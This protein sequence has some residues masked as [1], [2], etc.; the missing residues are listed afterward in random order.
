MGLLAVC[1]LSPSVSFGHDKPSKAVMT[2]LA[3]SDEEVLRGAVEE[4]QTSGDSRVPKLCLPLLHAGGDSIRRL[5]LRAIGSRY[6]QIPEAERA[7]YVAAIERLQKTEKSSV[8][9]RMAGRAL[10]L[11]RREYQADMFAPNPKGDLVAYER[12][13]L[14]CVLDTGRKT[15]TLIGKREDDLL[16]RFLPSVGNEAVRPFVWWNV[17]GSVA[18]FKMLFGRHHSGIWV[19][20]ENRNH[21]V[22]L[23]G[24]AFRKVT[25]VGRADFVV[26]FLDFK[27]W[28]GDVL[29]MDFYS[30]VAKP[31]G[32][33]RFEMSELSGNAFYDIKTGAKTFIPTVKN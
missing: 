21:H 20:F 19:W 9:L 6:A 24:E 17:N 14:P 5:A 10:G 22:Q 1:L 29:V 8:V 7:S 16:F 27:E 33:D 11:L 13:G 18:A 3:S 12:R 31:S 23:D 28:K 26:S 4:I 25:G 30:S 2:R 15:E 32:K